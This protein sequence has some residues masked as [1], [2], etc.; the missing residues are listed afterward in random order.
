[1]W[2]CTPY[3]ID[4]IF[5]LSLAVTVMKQLGLIDL[6][7]LMVLKVRALLINT[8]SW[9]CQSNFSGS[10][11]KKKPKYHGVLKHHDEYDIHALM[12][13]WQSGKIRKN[14]WSAILLKKVTLGNCEET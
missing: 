14:T 9:N 12:R 7:N 5:S 4:F 3:N 11:K 2:V 1:M 10:Y 13:E 8:Q 6:R